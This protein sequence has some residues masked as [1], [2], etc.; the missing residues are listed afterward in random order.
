MPSTRVLPTW[1]AELRGM[2]VAKTKDVRFRASLVAAQMS[3][4]GAKPPV[5]LPTAPG[6]K[7]KDCFGAHKGK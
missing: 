4:S 7:R 3:A 6:R 2:T 1:A 5:V